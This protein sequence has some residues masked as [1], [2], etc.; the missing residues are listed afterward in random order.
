MATTK[1]IRVSQE[2]YDRIK[3]DLKPNEFRDDVLRRVFQLEART[4]NRRAPAQ[5]ELF[6]SIRGRFVIASLSR[7]RGGTKYKLPFAKGDIIGNRNI[8]QKIAA[9]AQRNRVSGAEIT[10][11]DRFFRR[12]GYLLRRKATA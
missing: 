7:G 3:Q 2:V 1:T 6:L 12:H 9:Y 10:G 5:K 8:R 4:S 11:I